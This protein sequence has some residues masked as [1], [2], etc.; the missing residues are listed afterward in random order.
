MIVPAAV[1]EEVVRGSEEY[2][3]LGLECTWF[4]IGELITGEWVVTHIVFPPQVSTQNDTRVT[5]DFTLD[6][7]LRKSAQRVVIWGHTHVG[8][9]A[10]NLSS[11]DQDTASNYV[12]LSNLLPDCVS[13][14]LVC[15]VVCPEIKIFNAFAPTEQGEAWST[16][17]QAQACSG[18]NVWNHEHPMGL[19]A[20]VQ[21]VVWD[22]TAGILVLDLRPPGGPAGAWLQSSVVD[23]AM[24]ACVRTVK[25]GH[26]Q[27]AAQRRR[28]AMR[29]SCEE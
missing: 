10:C 5:D 12:K 9:V 26:A 1:L 2:T 19:Y 14:D 27:A 8:G 21:N 16:T 11:I 7:C 23:D 29:W 24:H 3:K 22:H 13:P 4:G 6:N 20:P 17:E 25:C 28:V 18:S 15:I